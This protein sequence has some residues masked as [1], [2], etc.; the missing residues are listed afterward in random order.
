[1]TTSAQ[2]KHYL[3]YENILNQIRNV[4]DGKSNKNIDSLNYIL[5][6]AP[7]VCMNAQA[8][9]FEGS[10]LY[11]QKN[12]IYES[13]KKYLECIKMTEKNKS[14]MDLPCYE[15]LIQ[16]SVTKLFYIYRRRGEYN[17][18]LEIVLQY[19]KNLKYSEFKSFLATTQ[20]DLGNYEKAI[21]EFNT[22]IK[23]NT[24]NTANKDGFQRNKLINF[25]RT[26]NAHSFIAD[27][28][29][30]LYKSSQNT[31]MLDSANLHY[32]KSYQ[33]GN[34]FNK[35]FSYNAILYYSRLAKIEYYKKN[36]SKAVSYYNVYFNH[37]EIN[38]NVFTYQ[39]YCIGLAE[40]YLKLNKPNLT[41][42]YLAQL[43][44]AYVANPGSEEFYIAGLNVYMDAYLQKKDDKNALHYARMYLEEIKKLESNKEKTH[45]VMDFLNIK[46]SNEKAKKIIELKNNWVIFLVLVCIFTVIVVMVRIYKFDAKQKQYRHIIQSLEEEVQL[47]DDQLLVEI[48]EEN[49][50]KSKYLTDIGEF[51]KIQKKLLRLESKKEFLSTE[52]KL[53]YLA[54]KLGTNTSYL[55]SF[56]NYYLEKG[57]NQYLQE[58][59]I[60]YLLE[61]L[62]KESIYHKYTV[63]AIS[64]HI[65]YKS[66]S[67]FAKMFKQFTGENFSSYLDKI[68]DK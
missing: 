38:K 41:L 24:P 25:Y 1:M 39:S 43:D 57:F 44:S 51:E 10:I 56:F 52:F 66:A 2:N 20:Y 21:K 63:Q 64:E 47:K 30:K 7:E 60:E 14:E 23:I 34:K 67:A 15:S 9:Y 61:L 37:P 28:F 45:K 18:A 3:K 62:E 22:Y 11:V 32:K 46:E 27:A 19:E 17:K 13:E 42:K 31:I 54:K 55:S 68:K 65:G 33:D 29:I 36:Y 26:S 58:K 59:R 12:D 49:P 6:K 8:V 4:L 53:P 5:K 50:E 35:N 16:V 48:I 40:N